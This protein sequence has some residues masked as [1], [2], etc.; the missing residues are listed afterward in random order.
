[1]LKRCFLIVWCILLPVA[2][3]AADASPIKIGIMPFNSTLALIKTHQPIRAHL[4]AALGRPVEFYT[5]PDY[6]TFYRESQA[7]QFDMLITGPHFAVMSLASGYKPL[8]HYHAKLQPIFVVS[9]K[10]D[11]RSLTDLRG[12]KIG[13]SSRLSISSIGG[14]KWLQDHGLKAGKDYR[15]VEKPTHGAAVAAVSIGELDAAL[16]TFTPLKQIPDDVRAKITVLATEIKTPHLMTLVHERL[17]PV[18][19]ER[20]Y[21]AL[22]AFPSTAGGKKFFEETGYQGYD[23]IDAE[24]I[25]SLKPYIALTR[26]LLEQMGCK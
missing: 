23:S 5:A 26:N 3:H 12:K 24:D 9:R 16:T 14:I 6:L 4:Q 25:R 2:V 1:M 13:L 17:G 11:I 10:S 22:K 7:G 20:I 15:L 18:E 19:I 8:F 21:A